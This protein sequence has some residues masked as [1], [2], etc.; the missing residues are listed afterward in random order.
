M[1]G[2]M[3]CLDLRDLPVMLLI[4]AAAVTAQ[5]LLSRREPRRPGL[6]LPAAC[7]GSRNG[8]GSCGRHGL[9]TYDDI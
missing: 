7:S 6:I 3:I 5:V 9:T 4:T 2:F 8:G 1:P